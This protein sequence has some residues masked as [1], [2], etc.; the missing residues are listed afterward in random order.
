MAGNLGTIPAPVLERRDT[1]S[2]TYQGLSNGWDTVVCRTLDGF[3][4]PDAQEERIHPVW[5]D[6]E[7][8][9]QPVPAAGGLVLNNHMAF[10]LDTARGDSIRLLVK[11]DVQLCQSLTELL[12]AGEQPTKAELRVLKQLLC[13]IG[14]SVAAKADGVGHETKRSQY[15]SLA[16]K[17]GV[18]SQAE[19]SS[20]VLAHLLFEHRNDADS[21]PS[22][23]DDLFVD[24]IEAF[25]PAARV[26]RLRSRNGEWHRFI[27]IGPVSGHPIILLHSQI[28]PDIRPED[29][30]LLETAGIRLVIPLRHGAMAGPADRLDVTAH[31]DHACDGIDLA[32]SHFCGEQADLLPCV[33]GCA[34]GIEYARRHPERVRSIG[35]LG[36]CIKP[37]TGLGAAGRLRAGLLSLAS[38]HWR[39]LSNVLDFYGTRLKD[40]A[41]LRRF[42][43]RHYSECAADLAVVEAEYARPHQGERARQMFAASLQSIKQDFYH[44][45]NP[46]WDRFPVGQFPAAFFHGA[47]DFIHEPEAVKS[48]AQRY[49]E[50]PVH[51]I[52]SAGQLLYYDH[53]GP[54]LDA[55]AGFLENIKA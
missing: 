12:V 34:Y 8:L 17:L 9:G 53:F 35:F 24:L 48:L 10:A 26:A 23:H 16:R 5:V 7:A 27:D 38:A 2:D 28:L 52:P 11:S 19:L 37:S 29:V 39:L 25:V 21:P 46:R 50:V 42:F 30:A 41:A 1:D 14:L 6:I 40:P 33:S 54:M 36:T 31:L 49:G 55:Y 44:Q 47:D 18:R 15:K 4:I 32:R 22:A 43:V 13:G 51:F 20:R 45:A 3:L